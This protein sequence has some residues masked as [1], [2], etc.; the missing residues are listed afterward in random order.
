M[1]NY[2]IA[3]D[4]IHHDYVTQLHR[5]FHRARGR[6]RFDDGLFRATTPDKRNY[7]QSTWDYVA[8]RGRLLSRP[9]RRCRTRACVYQMLKQHY[10]RYTPEMVERVRH[11]GDVPAS[12]RHAGDDGQPRPG[13]DHHVR[14][15]AG[16]STP[17]ARR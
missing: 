7:D 17:S 5:L 6:S 9:I 16:R 14:A 2:L 15:W 12:V 11:A 13:R 8:R 1:I 10:S 3:N 4:K